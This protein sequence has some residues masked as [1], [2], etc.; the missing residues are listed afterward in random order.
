LGR[1]IAQGY[2]KG[3]LSR[4]GESVFYPLAD[5]S[6]IEAEICSPVFIDPDGDRQNV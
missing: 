5:G 6:M 1:S 2:V 3:G 4:M